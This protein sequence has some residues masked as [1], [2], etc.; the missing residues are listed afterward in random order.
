M[1]NL[2]Q[3]SLDPYVATGIKITFH[4]TLGSSMTG[5]VTAVR[6]DPPSPYK[7]GYDIDV[8]DGRK[9]VIMTPDDCFKFQAES[10]HA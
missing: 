10:D 2:T 9:V 5:T 7:N 8:D 6:P 3:N 1:H 4:H